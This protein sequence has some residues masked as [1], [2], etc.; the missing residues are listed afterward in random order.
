MSFLKTSGLVALVVA[1]TMALPLPFTNTFGYFDA[2]DRLTKYGSVE[3]AYESQR[4]ECIITGV[5]WDQ[6]GALYFG[7]GAEIAYENFE[8]NQE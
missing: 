7:I 5:P 3:N 1:G 2:K 6:I 4:R 8:K